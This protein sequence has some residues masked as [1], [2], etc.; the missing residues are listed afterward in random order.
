MNVNDQKQRSLLFN[1]PKL[2]APIASKVGALTHTGISE[3]FTGIAQEAKVQPL[4]D[5]VLMRDFLQLF[6]NIRSL[7]EF[8]T[9]TFGGVNH[10]VFYLP[11][12]NVENLSGYAQLS[13]K[14]DRAAIVNVHTSEH[15][16]PTM[17]HE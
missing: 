8:R 16:I 10:A 1:P 3:Y 17:I 13:T 6:S 5:L 14:A 2:S 4:F 15:R 7:G 9:I 11:D 12:P